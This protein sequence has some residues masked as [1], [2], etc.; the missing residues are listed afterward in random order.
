[1][2]DGTKMCLVTVMAEEWIFFVGAL[3]QVLLPRMKGLDMFLL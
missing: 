3:L 2:Q 1:M